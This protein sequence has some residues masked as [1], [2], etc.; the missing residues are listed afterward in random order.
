MGGFWRYNNRKDRN[1]GG[2]PCGTARP[3]RNLP[4]KEV[5]CVKIVLILAACA[6]LLF[7]LTALVTYRVRVNI[8]WMYPLGLRTGKFYS[9]DYWPLLPWGFLF[10]LGT[11]LGPWLER[12]RQPRLPA[13]VACLARRS[14]E[15]YLLHQPLLY[16]L[17]CLFLGK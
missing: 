1:S 4:K 3:L 10:A 5:L 12:Q 9:A 17:C 7:L 6:A 2:K 14:L 13:V 15:V 8:M 11:C 16:G